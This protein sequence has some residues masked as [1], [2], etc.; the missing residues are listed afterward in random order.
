MSERR[1]AMAQ[2]GVGRDAAFGRAALFRSVRAKL[3]VSFVLV[4]VAI[5]VVSEVVDLVGL[6]FTPYSGTLALNRLEAAASLNLIADSKKAHLVGWLRE[7]RDDA[8]VLSASEMVDAQVRQLRAA[9]RGL[10]EA[11]RSD[12]EIWALLRNE[13]S[14]RFLEDLFRTAQRSHGGSARV[15]LAQPETGIIFLSTDPADLGIDISDAPFFTHALRHRAADVSDVAIDPRTG[16]PALRVSHVISKIPPEKVS[17]LLVFQFDVDSVFRP[18]LHTGEGLGETGEALLVNQDGQ[19]LTSLKYPLPNGTAARPLG[20]RIEAQ[21]ASLASRGE[22]GITEAEDYRG[23]P[24]LAAYRHIRVTSDWGWGLVVKRD[25]A[26]LFAPLRARLVHSAVADLAATLLS[27][28]V[29]VFIARNLTHPI[30]SL[31]RAARRVAEGDLEVRAPVTTSDEVGALATTFN[32]MVEQTAT[33]HR[34]FEEQVQQRTA[35]LSQA[36]TSLEAEVQ[37]RKR[38]E[39]E[40]RRHRHQL[41]MLVEERTAALVKLSE[42]Q[43]TILDSVRATIWYKDTE[44]NFLRVNKAAAESVG[45]AVEQI[46]G[47]S[48]QELF[49]DEADHYYEDDLEVIRSGKP[50]LGIVQPLRTAAGEELW[51]LADKIPYR[52]DAGKIAGVIVFAIDITERKRAEE[53][54]EKRSDEQRKIVNLMA[55]REVR[56]AELKEE[57]RELKERLAEHEGRRAEKETGSKSQENEAWRRE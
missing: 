30:V 4:A 57:V 32:A 2:I 31:G 54:L 42:E 23:E 28:G 47:K 39:E 46:E 51:V 19:I 21:P 20:F 48:C 43:R 6:P 38:M 13:H 45:L 49:P 34:E 25:R 53:A 11:G 1:E 50:M 36:N 33:W 18:M 44:N 52:D 24:V 55:G 12:G 8:R 7:R 15:F 29:V 3:I 14:Y 27:L 16:R 26:E 40:L 5:V 41:K 9:L 17:A 22:E 56:M 10:E 35:D 37:G